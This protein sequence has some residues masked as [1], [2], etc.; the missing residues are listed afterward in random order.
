VE[1]NP[2]DDGDDDGDITIDEI[3]FVED[4]LLWDSGNLSC[5]IRVEYGHAW[6]DFTHFAYSTDGSYSN[7]HEVKLLGAKAGTSYYFRICAQEDDGSQSWFT[8]SDS[9]FTLQ[10]VTT[11]ESELLKFVMLAVEKDVCIGDCLYLRLPSG[12]HFV[13]DS[14]YQSKVNYVYNFLQEENA[15]TIDYAWF[16]HC[17][18]DHYG[19]FE[20]YNGSGL[21]YKADLHFENFFYP[22]SSTHRDTYNRLKEKASSQCASATP[23][24]EGTELTFGDVLIKILHS[25]AI[26]N[27]ENNCSIMA[28]ISYRNVNILCGGDAEHGE[29]V[30]VMAQYPNLLRNVNVFKVHHHGRSDANGENFIAAMRPRVSMIPVDE[31]SSDPNYPLP[32]PH[33]SVIELLRDFNIDI[34]RIDKTDPYLDTYQYDDIKL[35]SDGYFFEV[36]Y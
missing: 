23:L 21:W 12:E 26:D 24:P 6:G 25:G 1:K 11:S 30:E 34:F 36:Y 33:P 13:I 3:E 15:L 17:H 22:A 2:F 35:I 5:R 10:E 4:L 16:T 29:E 27:I 14:G 8:D 9:L 28:Y 7:S 31:R 19:G 32:L 18:G 20:G